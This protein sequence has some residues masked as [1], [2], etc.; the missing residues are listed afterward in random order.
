MS[1]GDRTHERLL[2]EI[3]R[4][5]GVPR[6]RPGVPPEP[7]NLLLDQTMNLGHLVLPSEDPVS[8]AITNT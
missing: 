3:I 1:F 7:R 5:V 6:E 4:P 8:G 2:D